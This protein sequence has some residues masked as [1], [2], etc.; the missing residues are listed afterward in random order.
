MKKVLLKRVSVVLVIVVL[1]GSTLTYGA[2]RRTA[3]VT[4]VKGTV[5]VT[6]SGG[7]RKINAFKGMNLAEGDTLIIGADGQMTLKLDN[8]KEVILNA[9]TTMNIQDLK[10][11]NGNQVT[12]LNQTKGSSVT[13]IDNK[14]TAGS[15]FQQRTP[16]AIMGV[17]GTVW[18]TALN[19]E[20]TSNMVLN[21]SI[22]VLSS[23]IQ[24]SL[25]T[26][27]LLPGTYPVTEEAPASPVQGT[28]PASVI[29]TKL[30]VGDRPVSANTLIP[31]S[32]QIS[33]GSTVVIVA[34][35]G[36]D[37]LEL[38]D[39]GPSLIDRFIETVGRSD[40]GIVIPP[41]SFEFGTVYVGYGYDDYILDTDRRNSGI[42]RLT[43]ITD[44]QA[45]VPA[46]MLDTQGPIDLQ[47]PVNPS[48]FVLNL[49]RS[50]DRSDPQGSVYPPASQG[51]FS[52]EIVV[53]SGYSLQSNYLPASPPAVEI[54]DWNRVEAPIIQ[55]FAM[56]AEQNPNLIDPNIVQRLQNYIKENPQV[57]NEQQPE[58]SSI[59]EV[60]RY[61]PPASMPGMQGPTPASGGGGGG[62]TTSPRLYVNTAS[63]LVGVIKSNM[64]VTNN[65]TR[66]QDSLRRIIVGVESDPIDMQK[67]LQSFLTNNIIS[68]ATYGTEDTFFVFTVQGMGISSKEQ[69]ELIIFRE[70]KTGELNKDQL[71]GVE[72]KYGESFINGVIDS[73]TNDITIIV[74]DDYDFPEGDDSAGIRAINESIHT[75]SYPT[76]TVEL[77]G[78]VIMDEEERRYY[79]GTFNVNNGKNTYDVTVRKAYTGASIKEFTFEGKP[80][81]TRFITNE[82][83][84]ELIIEVYMPKGTD[85]DKL[86]PKVTTAKGASYTLSSTDFSE[87]VTCTVTSEN[88]N[89]NEYTV[90]VYS[91]FNKDQIYGVEMKY[92]ERF[93]NG[94]IDSETNDITIIVPDD[95][96][97]PE[98]DDSD[99]IRAINE[100]IHTI[101]YPTTTVELTGEVIMDEEERP[102]YRGT[103]NVNNG[104]NT[105]Y[106]T[107]RKAYT[108]AGINEFTFEGQHGEGQLGGTR[109]I[110]DE[111]TGKPII[112]V[113]M[114]IGTELD[115]LIPEVTTSKGASYTLSSTDFSEP[116][117]CTVTSED[118]N[119]SNEYTV[120][121]YP[122][123]EP[124]L[125]T[126]TVIDDAEYEYQ[127]PIS[128]K[129]TTLYIPALT[130][131]QESDPQ[132]FDGPKPGLSAIFSEGS[133]LRE[134][135]REYRNA[136]PGGVTEMTATYKL[137]LPNGYTQDWEITLVRELFAI[138]LEH[139]E[140]GID[141]ARPLLTGEYLEPPTI[142]T[143]S[144]LYF[145]STSEDIVG[146]VLY[147]KLDGAN[148]T[149]GAPVPDVLQ[150]N[151]DFPT[152]IFNGNKN[153]EAGL[154]RFY[155]INNEEKAVYIYF[156]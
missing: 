129:T 80:A 99:G 149:Q 46:Y 95:Y 122:Y 10:D 64:T 124:R 143:G 98:G 35:Q 30:L 104:K 131:I 144:S 51:S 133:N 103:F 12:T 24:P 153:V 6:K 29:L 119:S 7:E 25:T 127:Y 11:N 19:E 102:Y 42:I 20:G 148:P 85:L 27:D 21:G 145:V 66:I 37:M 22:S 16:T 18:G 8:D 82:E 67:K 94:V 84:G 36:D 105:Y 97:F 38:K 77:T 156:N 31:P 147:D 57:L 44:V 78:E 116:V 117:T 59:R 41:L 101:S 136:E 34:S 140:G 110:T 96:D 125:L 32:V 75:I 28:P 87:P 88:G 63:E 106:V 76:T 90:R 45:Q 62:S 83:T 146:N 1:M 79:R 74:P 48:K 111:M 39:P 69:W 154:Y 33:Q 108:G 15:S 115:K 113:Y 2:P 47:G 150:G 121:V 137:E 151:N 120:Y 60:P 14:L 68:T 92:G 55:N 155:Y 93:I 54:I 130:T 81:E 118:G 91:E 141:Y 128:S 61:I 138:Y 53:Q 56:I 123:G 139:E 126:V 49:L 134:M 132:G 71:Y 72:M 9:N 142:T 152:L 73:E 107:V 23:Y 65:A 86:I 26:Y 50:I 52:T 114:P 58:E 3:V 70:D 135:T 109:F 5:K 43:D 4:E 112:E 17:R 40:R 100:S 13:K 89:T